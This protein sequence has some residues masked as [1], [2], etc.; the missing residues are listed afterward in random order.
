MTRA[1]GQGDRSRVDGDRASRLLH[2][3]FNAYLTKAAD[4]SECQDIYDRLA[5]G[6]TAHEPKRTN[7][8]HPVS[9]PQ[10][11]GRARR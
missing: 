7:G 2:E 11:P 8:G 9:N 4:V 5:Y 10:P 3:A 1:E 6:G